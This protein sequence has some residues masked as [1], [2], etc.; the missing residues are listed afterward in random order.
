MKKIF[1]IL[2]FLFI[3]TFVFADESIDSVE[4]LKESLLNSSVEVVKLS[5]DITIN[6]L[7][8]NHY[9]INVDGVSRVL[10]LNG[11]TLTI[12]ENVSAKIV[13]NSNNSTFTITDSKGTGL[14]KTNREFATVYSDYE[15]N[16]ID[17]IDFD[18]ENLRGNYMFSSSTTKTVKMNVDK[19]DFIYANNSPLSGGF[20]LTIKSLTVKP[21][22]Q[23]NPIGFYNDSSK[24]YLSDIVSNYSDI[25]VNN[26]EFTND[27]TTTYARD[28]YFY[29]VENAG[30]I[31][32]P[33]LVT[34]KFHTNGGS[35]INDIEVLKGSKFREVKPSDPVKTDVE[36]YGWYY[37]N[38]FKKY[39]DINTPILEDMDIYARWSKKFSLVCYDL[40]RELE[41]SGGG[42]KYNTELETYPSEISGYIL[43]NNEDNNYTAIPSDGYVFKGW[44]K[45]SKNGEIISTNPTLDFSF[46]SGNSGKIYLLFIKSVKVNFNT[47]GGNKIDSKIIGYSDKLDELPTPIREGFIFDGWYIDSSFSEEFGINTMIYEDITLYAKWKEIISSADV[48]FRIPY[49]LLTPDTNLKPKD[50]KKYTATVKYIY[51]NSDLSYLNN[52]SIFE[53]DNYYTYR[54]DFEPKDG[55]VFTNDTVFKFNGKVSE[56]YGAIYQRQLEYMADDIPQIVKPV[57]KIKANNNKFTVTWDSQLAAVKYVLYKSTNNKKWSKGINITTNSYV[58][59]SLTYGKT[60]YY[61]VKVCD[62]EKCS[63]LSKVVSKKVKPNKVNLSIKSAGTNN[64]KLSW[65]KVSTTGY[66]IY[67][68]TNNKTWT[69]INTITK[70]TTLTYNNK[71]L[72]SNKTYYYK[73]RAYKVVG[74]SRIYGSYSEVVSTKTAPVKPKLS[75]S[76]KDFNKFSLTISSSK[77]AKSYLI[78]R[79]LDNKTYKRI[80]SLSESGS[81]IDSPLEL[82]KTY[83]YRVRACNSKNRCSAWVYASK[84]ATPMPPSIKLSTSSKKVIIELGK[85]K[86]VDGYEL[87]RS[88]SKNGK[89]SKIATLDNETDLVITNKTTRWKTYYYK[90]RSYMLKDGKKIYS[91]YTKIKSIMSK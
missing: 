27:R 42:I 64:I 88:T 10:D 90:A 55:Y 29:D 80:I 18:Y 11:Y 66:V 26:E 38:E 24:V 68:S 25:F 81:I 3:P 49:A 91:S 69:R 86:N 34:L 72:S 9:D 46:D 75:I 20:D 59:K 43:E 63:S 22:E 53:K 67:R 82:G 57:I 30:I 79:S 51:K 2:C 58:D 36:F 44:A 52:E 76:L 73:V 48:S 33:A 47:N 77:G 62:K 87:Y 40:S 28:V 15:N 16:K 74:W 37:D 65:D 35:T 50:S 23:N 56:C 6:S 4:K 13:F 14:I 41:N 1:I 85:V 7:D 39:I 78:D 70:N 19:V 5:N 31:I 8:N 32:K 60:Y 83:Y 71:Y 89:Y 84:K 17:L 54:I 61:K 12:G 21:K 45:N